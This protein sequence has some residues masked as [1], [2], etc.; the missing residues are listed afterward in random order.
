MI[1]IEA[2]ITICGDIHGQY[3]DL[4][5]LFEVAGDPKNTRFLFLGD[6]VDRGYFSAE[7]VLY[8]WALKITYPQT[9]FL[10]RG[11]HECRHLT[12]YFTFKQ[13]CV[14]K[15]DDS[16]YENCVNS[17]DALPLAGLLN[18][19]FLCLHGGISPELR[20]LDDIRAL[21]R[22]TEPPPYGAM[23]DIIWS[24]PHE[25]YGNER[26]SEQ[27]T[28]N[29][30]RGC[31]YFYTY[32]AVVEFLTNNGLLSI[33]RAH[34]AQDA[35][36]KMYRKNQA[37][38]FPSLIT[39]FSAPNYLDVYNNKA[40]VLKYENNIMNIRQFNAST[41]PYWLPNFMDVFTWSLPFVGEKVTEMLINILNICSAEETSHQDAQEAVQVLEDLEESERARKAEVRMRLQKKIVAIGKMAKYFNTLREESETVLQLKGLTP[42]GRLPPG[43]LTQGLHNVTNVSSFSDAKKLDM[44]NER[45]PER[46]F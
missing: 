11:N 3:Y 20:T 41:H 15:Y 18:G 35:G 42:G 8:L 39:I 40:A 26:T 16:F 13:E 27:Y 31:S 23:C 17:F 12:E 24:D 34:E 21:D 25:D 19:Q 33:I 44:V 28:T 6:Y 7:C 45:M 1:D 9:M 37:T 14:I 30:V 10:L 29:S 38:G 5:K 36:Y 22:F 2:P 32:A 4:M 43:A 46:N